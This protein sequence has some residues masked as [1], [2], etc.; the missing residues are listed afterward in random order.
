MRFNNQLMTGTFSLPS[1]SLGSFSK[2]VFVLVL[3]S[4]D[5]QELMALLIFLMTT[6][7]T[8][9]SQVAKI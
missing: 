5:I 7:L 4:E 3:V 9:I 8:A 1:L 6:F 2:Q